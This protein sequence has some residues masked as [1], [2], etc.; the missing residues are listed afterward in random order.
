MTPPW[1]HQGVSTGSPARASRPPPPTRQVFTPSRT[2]FTSLLSCLHSSQC[3]AHAAFFCARSSLLFHVSTQVNV[4]PTPLLS[5][6]PSRTIDPQLFDLLTR[7]K[8]RRLGNKTWVDDDLCLYAGV[9][10]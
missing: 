2:I 8:N 4:T 1:L 10:R 7:A 5:T 9:D 6:S 3:V